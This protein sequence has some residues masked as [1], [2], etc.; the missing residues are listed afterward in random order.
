MRPTDTTDYSKIDFKLRQDLSVAQNLN[1]SL[2]T[3]LSNAK[4]ELWKLKQEKINGNP[5]TKK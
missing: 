5:R 3:D 4:E 1:N 2:K